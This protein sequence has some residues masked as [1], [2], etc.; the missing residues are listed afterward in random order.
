MS[1]FWTSDQHYY[2]RNIISYTNRPFSSVEE[3][4]EELIRLHNSV[5]SPKDTV[6]HLGD[7]SLNKTAPKEILHRLNGEH[8]LIMGNHD[9]CHPVHA[10]GEKLQKYRKVYWEAG[11]KSLEMEGNIEI[12]GVNC[13]MNHFPYYDPNP[14]FDQRYPKLRPEDKGSILLHGH[15]HTTWKTKLSPKGSLMINV[16][17]DQWK[18]SPVSLGE[19]ENLIKDHYKI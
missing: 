17:V 12:G 4:N 9:A 10:K 13:L 11:F 2:H 7:F 18:M 14:D 5:V 16:G 8:H 19:I 15:V 6:Y 1:I 3:M